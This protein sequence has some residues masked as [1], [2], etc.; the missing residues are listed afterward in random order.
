MISPRR[1]AQVEEP[2]DGRSELTPSVIRFF[3]TVLGE[4]LFVSNGRFQD[5]CAPFRGIFCSSHVRA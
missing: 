5:A 3:L 4:P 1:P 2:S